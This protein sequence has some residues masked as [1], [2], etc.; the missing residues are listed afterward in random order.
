MAASA[1]DAANPW[2]E[3]LIENHVDQSQLVGT[4]SKAALDKLREEGEHLFTGHFTTLDGAGRP[5]ATQ[6][7]IPTK[8]E[9]PPETAFSRTHGMDAN[10]CSDCHNV[11]VIGA[12]GDFASNAF[13]SEGFESADFDSTDPQFSNERGS[14]SLFGAGLIDLLAREMTADLQ[15][16][17]NRALTDAR[18]SGNPVTAPLTSKGVSYGSITAAPDG[19]LDM[20]KIEGVDAD[21]VVR[22]FSQKGVMT[23]DPAVRHQCAQPAPRHGG[24]RAL[25]HTLDWDP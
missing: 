13:I 6:A 7:I 12:A 20:S 25:R 24:A 5:D 17:R 15:E 19:F 9:R 11:P 2:D 8:R 3:R 4:L 22:P 10:A 23:F 18:L 21:L 14:V 1:A 16:I